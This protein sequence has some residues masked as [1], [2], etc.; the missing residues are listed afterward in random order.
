[1]AIENQSE[2]L[3][4]MATGVPPPTISF[5]RDGVNLEST[6]A[7][8][9]IVVTQQTQPILNSN[10]SYMVTRTLG[11]YNLTRQDTGNYTCTATSV[12]EELGNMT[13]VDQDSV[14]LIVQS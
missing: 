6:D 11:I 5:L 14:E 9:R 8:A 2:V 7:A 12:I 13:L 10:G 3:T 1:M 4:C